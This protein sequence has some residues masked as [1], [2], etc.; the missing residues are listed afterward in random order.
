MFSELE[1][2]HRKCL[3]RVLRLHPRTHNV[4][5]EAITGRYSLVYSVVVRI[6]RFVY[7]LLCSSN[8]SVNF[9]VKC[10]NYQCVS[11]MGT[12]LQYIQC[13]LGNINFHAFY[14]VLFPSRARDT[15]INEME[16]R[17]QHVQNIA[18]TCRE[19]IDA[20]DGLCAT[21]LSRQETIDLLDNLCIS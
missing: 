6:C 17:L 10:C 8:K 7:N 12:N 15:L 20:R 9:L 16:N 1:V 3:R 13:M 4:L 19:L 14:D 21:I 11:N 18:H 5:L 2:I